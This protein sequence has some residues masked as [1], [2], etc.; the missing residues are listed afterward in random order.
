[1]DENEWVAAQGKQARR[2]YKEGRRVPGDRHRAAAARARSMV[3]TIGLEVEGIGPVDHRQ[4]LNDAWAA[5]L[6]PGTATT[7]M[8][9]P[10][11]PAR[12]TLG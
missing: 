3:W 9:D 6:Q 8:V 11:D 12:M 7:V 1:M 10:A 4:A 5:Q 2:L